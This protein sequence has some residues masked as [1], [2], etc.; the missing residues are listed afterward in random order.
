KTLT[1]SIFTWDYFVD[2]KK[3][4]NNIHLIEKELNLLNVLIGKRD[5][6]KEFIKLVSEYPNVRE[7]LPILIA[8]RNSKLKEF[9]VIDD[10]EKLKS[11]RKA[12]LFSKSVELTSKIK[13][14]LLNFFKESG[15]KN[16]FQ[17]KDIKNIVDYCFGVEVGMDTNARKNRTGKS[18]ES[19]VGKIIQKFAEKNNL[20]YIPQATQKKIKEKWNF[21]IKI[22]KTDRIFDFAIFEKSKK[23]IFMVETN[24]YSGGGSKLK[25]TAGEYQYLFD[26]LK[27][28]GID[29]IWITDGLGWKTTKKSLFETFLHNDYLLNIELVKKGV[30]KDI[31]L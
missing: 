20:D 24:Y 12:E 15:L 26:F 1:D 4:K 31:I 3:V 10:F 29:L 7:V 27:N 23:K 13:E 17:D 19:I 14:D 9:K 11:E 21:D 6:E 22:D 28:Q 30:L 5:V 25:S 16:I 2:F 18:M 8:I